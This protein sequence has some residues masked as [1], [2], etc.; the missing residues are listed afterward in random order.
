MR[1]VNRIVKPRTASQRAHARQAFRS[2]APPPAPARGA[3]VPTASWWLSC[4]RDGFTSRATTEAE[5]MQQSRF[6]RVSDPT[7]QS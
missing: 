3:G 1:T 2:P 5:R 4:D 6:A 7:Y